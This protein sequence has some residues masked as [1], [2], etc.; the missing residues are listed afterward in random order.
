MKVYQG[1]KELKD[2]R[3][4][5]QS[6]KLNPKML[7]SDLMGL[8]LK[9]G[10]YSI[11]DDEL[12]ISYSEY[13]KLDIYSNNDVKLILPPEVDSDRVNHII[14]ALQILKVD[15]PVSRKMMGGW[16]DSNNELVEELNT[17]ISFNS[18]FTSLRWNYLY[19]LMK[20]IKLEFKQESIAIMF[21]DSLLLI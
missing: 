19:C 3:I 20:D 1:S 15:N 18:G 10:G 13:G 9:Y 16:I 17:I 11:I 6:I 21:N 7:K 2:V 8:A 5:D 4:L 12:I 14:K